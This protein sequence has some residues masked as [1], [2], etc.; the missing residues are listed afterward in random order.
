MNKPRIGHFWGFA[1][2]LLLGAYFIRLA[3]RSTFIQGGLKKFKRRVAIES[4]VREGSNIPT[5]V[6]FKSARDHPI[7]R[8]VLALGLMAFPQALIWKLGWHNRNWKL[9]HRLLVSNI[10]VAVVCA[11]LQTFRNPR[12]LNGIRKP[13]RILLLFSVIVGI[14]ASLLWTYNP[15]WPHYIP[16]SGMNACMFLF[17]T[18]LWGLGY[19]VSNTGII[20]TLLLTL[21]LM[22][23]PALLIWYGDIPAV[24]TWTRTLKIGVTC[25]SLAGMITLMLMHLFLIIVYWN[26]SSIE[27]VGK[28]IANW[29]TPIPCS[30]EYR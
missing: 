28:L 22:A 29:Q 3:I 13:F 14:P 4:G 25:G 17:I 24:G 9:W 20:V 26:V 6:W 7:L 12:D 1:S 30:R 5:R 16:L 19:V 15:A 27:I 2:G 18:I 8:H 11:F 21:Y 10:A 23:T